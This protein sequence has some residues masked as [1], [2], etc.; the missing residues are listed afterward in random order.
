M[1]SKVTEAHVAARTDDILNAALLL[2][3]QKGVE[4]TAMQEI[5]FEAGLSTGAVYRYFSSKEELLRAC[6]ARAVDRTNQ[7]I[8]DATASE[9]SAL[10]ALGEIGRMVL[11][12]EEPC[13][14]AALQVEFS[15]AASRDPQWWGKEQR[16]LTLAVIDQVE[17]LV[18]MAQERGEL[19]AGIDSR[20]LAVALYALVPGLRATS[21]E[22][23]EDPGMVETMEVVLEVLRKTAH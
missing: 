14:K 15:L 16:R 9:A 5:A 1:M 17:I 4:K 22:L 21:L 11:T 19:D 13:E 10:E 18:R 12:G 2:F 20:R 3:S 23:G 7:V 6:F 8:A